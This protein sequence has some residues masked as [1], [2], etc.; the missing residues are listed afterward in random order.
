MAVFLAPLLEAAVAELGPV[1]LRAGAALLGGATVA[2]TASLPGDTQKDD[3]KAK[4]VPRAL[5]RTGERCKKCPADAGGV[6]ITRH[7][8]SPAARK[9]QG[10]VTG[11]PYGID[12]GRTGWNEEWFWLGTDW[13]GFVSEECLLQEAKGNYD[14]FFEPWGR[15]AKVFMEME[16]TIARHASHIHRNPPTRLKWYFQ[17]PKAY[18]QMKRVLDRNGV[19]S[20]LKP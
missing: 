20:E 14:I 16:R 11:R 3:S 7:D 5:P 13:D 2:G 1:L 10:Y 6:K 15:G 18:A 8:M 4:P 19:E 17:T 9:Y 12:E